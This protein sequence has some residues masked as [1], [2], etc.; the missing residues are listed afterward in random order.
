MV[1]KPL[2]A[3]FSPLFPPMAGAKFQRL[4]PATLN[5]LANGQ[6]MSASSS[7][8]QLFPGSASQMRRCNFGRKNQH[9]LQPTT[10]DTVATGAVM[11]KFS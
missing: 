3:R 9:R 6:L 1:S 11:A 5:P 8:G 4:K 2:Q 7:Q 10:A